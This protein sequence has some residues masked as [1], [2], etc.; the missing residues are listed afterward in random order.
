VLDLL[1]VVIALAFF[2]LA[3]AFVKFCDHIVG[4]DDLADASTET[5][6]VAEDVAA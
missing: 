5:P 3:A 1:F 2:A 4:P 6:T